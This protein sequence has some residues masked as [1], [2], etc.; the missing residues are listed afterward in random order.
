LTKHASMHEIES[1]IDA[2]AKASGLVIEK[3]PAPAA[4]EIV[5]KA[6]AVFVD[7]NPRSWWLSLKLP[8]R[9]LDSDKVGLTE[10]LP[11]VEGTCWFVPETES[12]EQPVYRVATQ[13]LEVLI[14]EC[15]FFEYYVLGQDLSWLVAES[16]HNTFYV[17]ER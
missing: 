3:Q 10:V 2:A 17:C 1:W 11:N 7:D 15:P 16:D 6:Q 5:E 14:K 12:E 4:R 9:Q 8:S 13:D